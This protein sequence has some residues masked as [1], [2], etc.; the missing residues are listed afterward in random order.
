MTERRVTFEDFFHSPET[1]SVLRELYDRYAAEDSFLH[2]FWTC[3][4]VIEPIWKLARALPDVPKA[5]LY[6]TACTGYAGFLGAL[7]SHR[8]GSPLLL[9]EHGIYLKERIQ[10]IY[11][12]PWISEFA[13]LRPSITEPLGSFRRLWIGF[14]DVLAR[15][16]YS[17]AA[18]IVSLFGANASVQQHFGAAPEKISIVANGI[19]AESCDAIAQ[20]RHAR[21]GFHPHSGVVGFLGRVVS[22]KDVKTLLRAARLVCDAIPE[23]QFLIVGPTSEEPEYHRE[24]VDLTQQLQLDANVQFLG[25]RQRDEVLPLMDV[26]VLTSISEGLPF[27]ILEAMASGIPIVS[28]DVGACRELLEGRPGEQ[29]ALGACGIVTD[30]GASEQIARALIWTL[31]NRELQDQMSS[32]GRERVRRHYHERSMLHGYHETY[33]RLMAASPSGPRISRR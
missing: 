7:L 5:R 24:C 30:I 20:E 19:A 28:T 16:C 15:L 4:Y 6:H 32:V 31:S 3:R 27:V 21:R 29:P 2:F 11:R 10:D 22:I 13:P 18:H 1:W 23:T 8:T 33:E 17:E 26:M 14:F 12:S 9:S 25:A